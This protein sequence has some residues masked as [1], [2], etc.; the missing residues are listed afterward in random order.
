MKEG[1]IALHMWVSLYQS[2]LKLVQP[3]RML[4]PFD[5]KLGTSHQYLNDSYST[6]GRLVKVV[7]NFVVMGALVVHKHVFSHC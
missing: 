6:A 2:H 4:N 3:I 7:F 1:H 5:F